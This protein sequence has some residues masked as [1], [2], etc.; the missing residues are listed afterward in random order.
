MTFFAFLKI[1]N[2]NKVKIIAIAMIVGILSVLITKFLPAKYDA[3]VALNVIRVNREE[4]GDYQYDGFYAIQAS[5]LFAETIV[6]WLETPAVVKE[7]YEQSGRK[8]AVLSLSD[9]AGA[10]KAKK[11]S[12]Q[13]I[14]VKFSSKTEE[15]AKT[16]AS[17]LVSVVEKKSQASLETSEKEAVFEIKSAD[18]VIIKRNYDAGITFFAGL[19]TG[20][21][22]GILWAAGRNYFYENRN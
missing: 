13:N 2:Q 15:E 18:P 14:T 19:I 20:L 3:S 16:I 10:F 6:S 22:L 7:I 4:T 11:L 5:N 1:I 12:S 21:A 8:D 17:S 9:F